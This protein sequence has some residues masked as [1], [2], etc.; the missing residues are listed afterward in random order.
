MFSCV[1]EREREV[2]L[3]CWSVWVNKQCSRFP[4]ADCLENILYSRGESSS[5]VLVERVFIIV[6]SGE[7]FPHKV[8]LA[9][10]INQ[11]LAAEVLDSETAGNRQ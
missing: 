11:L 10:C 5:R 2:R 4:L 8:G 7:M 1:G 9:I 6:L 3:D